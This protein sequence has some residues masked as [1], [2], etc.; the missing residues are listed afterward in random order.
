MHKRN[1]QD[2]PCIV[3][4]NY[5]Y[6]KCVESFFYDKF[7]CQYP[8]NTYQDLHLPVCNNLTTIKNSAYTV[9]RENGK[10]REYYSNLQRAVYTKNKCLVP[11]HVTRYFLRYETLKNHNN[12]KGQRQRSITITFDHFLIEHKDEYPACDIT[13]IIGEL[14]GNFGFFLGGSILACYDLIVLAISRMIDS[15]R[16]LRTFYTKLCPVGVQE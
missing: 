5:N 3:D 6:Y 13:C 14:G 15:V 8:W 12:N 11:C 9:N 4:S 16:R 1:T 2:R 7:R 10:E